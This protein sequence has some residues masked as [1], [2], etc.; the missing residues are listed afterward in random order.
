MVAIG[1]CSAQ[2][3]MPALWVL[4]VAFPMIIALGG[5]VGAIGI[6]LLGVEISIALSGVF[7]GI[8]VFL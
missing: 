7:L 2:L 8:M 3:G 4:P 1:L 6:G 5:V